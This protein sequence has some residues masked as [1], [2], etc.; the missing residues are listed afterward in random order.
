MKTSSRCGAFC[1]ITLLGLL[2]LAPISRA[3]DNAAPGGLQ[4]GDLVG[5]CGDSITEQR[6]YSVFMADYL[7]MCQPQPKLSAIQFGWSGEQAS[8]FLDRMKNDAL[9][10]KPTVV[11]TC[12]GMNDG[13]YA[14]S[15]PETLETYRK[16]M[17]AIVDTFKANGVRFIVIGSP[18]AVDTFYYKARPTSVEVYNKT[19]ADL[20]QVAKEVAQ[21]EGVSFAD[22]HGV[23]IDVMAKAKAQN[24][25]SYC[26]IGEDGV[27]PPPNGHIVMAYAFLKGLGCDGNIGTITVDMIANRA[28]ATEGTK[29]VSFT[30]GTVEL[31]ST[32]YPF[33]F[34]GD[35][36]KDPSSTKGI[37]PF[38]PFNQE[39]NRYLLVV[40]NAPGKGLKVTWGTQTKTFSA[41]DLDKG[42]NL[43]AEFLD[44]PFSAPFLAVQEKIAAQQSFET[45]ACK[46][47]LHSLLGWATAL[48]DSQDMLAQLPPKIVAKWESLRDATAAAIVPV[49][50]E[51][52]LEPAE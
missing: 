33:C 38:L 15:T 9:V 51:I 39:L 7:L 1:A 13:H 19:L 24:G 29:V 23:M 27:H 11:T 28:E 14:A 52:K 47:L 35:N 26:V 4:S 21:Q 16:S 43:A 10:F 50:H 22:V 42:V 20:G 37:L 5:I 30:N 44:N 32:R 49:K 46:E 18:G 41:S 40:K 12:Y 17:T 2:S 34:V 45:N 25:D 31:E 8:G 48:P 36:L 3:A 6:I